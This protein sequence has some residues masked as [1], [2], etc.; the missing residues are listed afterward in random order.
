MF[1]NGEKKLAADVRVVKMRGWSREL[2][3]DEGPEWIHP[4][5]NMRSLAAAAL[6]PGVGLRNDQRLG[7]PRHRHA[8]RDPRGAVDRRPAARSVLERPR[9]RAHF[10]P[11]HFTPA[12]RS[13]RAGA[14]Q[15][16]H[17]RR[18]PRGAAPGLLGIEIAVALRDLIRW[19]GTAR[20][21]NLLANGE[22]FAAWR[23]ERTPC[24]SSPRGRGG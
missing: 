2:W 22:A 10:S 20:A 24:R 1:V 14:G 3:Y 8:L 19:T 6:Y 11:I 5:P 7:R 13:S 9:S 4:S 15:D 23:R 17:G 16:P 12:R 18:G 21:L